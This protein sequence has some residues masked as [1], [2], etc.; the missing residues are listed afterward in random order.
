[1]KKV[2]MLAVIASVI[3]ASCK[4]ETNHSTPSLGKNELGVSATVT[5]SVTT[6]ADAMRDAFGLSTDAVGVFVT[7]TLYTP[8]VAWYTYDGVSLWVPPSLAEKKIFLSNETATVYGFYPADATVNGSTSLVNDASNQIDL[9]LSPTVGLD[10]T[11]QKDYMYA[12]TRAGVAGSYTYPLATASNATDANK[13]DLSFHHALSKLSFVVNRDITYTGVGKLSK[14]ELSTNIFNMPNK[15]LVLDGTLTGGTPV[16][17][18]ILTGTAVDINPYSLL[19]PS[20]TV[21]AKGLFAPLA[22]T[23]G[24][25]LTLTIDG[26]EMSVALPASMPADSWSPNKNY[27]YTIT[28]L[29]TELVVNS[30]AIVP[31]DDQIGGSTTVQ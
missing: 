17:N 4:K 16:T 22:T 28:V 24:T 11:G 29:G 10:G 6:R 5:G 23:M 25:T 9:L 1:M 12:T 27:I 3:L 19:N 15:M 13:V 8:H 14:I 20:T 21:S 2:I 31:W 30:V 26:K 7:G 18:L